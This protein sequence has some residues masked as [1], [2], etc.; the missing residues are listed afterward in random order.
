MLEI[1]VGI[2]GLKW[3]LISSRI[4]PLAYNPTLLFYIIYYIYGEEDH[5]VQS[6]I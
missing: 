2:L 6:E 3:M 4:T 5:L 1:S